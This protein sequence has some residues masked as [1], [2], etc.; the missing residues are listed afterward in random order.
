MRPGAPL[1][2]EKL[3][4]DARGMPVEKPVA[5]PPGAGGKKDEK[6]AALRTPASAARAA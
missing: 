1:A 5:P 3:D 4:V 6:K 2:P